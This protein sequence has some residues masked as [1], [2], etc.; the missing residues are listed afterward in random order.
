MA[1]NSVVFKPATQGSIT[2][3]YLTKVFQEAGVPNGII[4]SITGR[5]SEIGDYIITHPEINFINFTGST[6]AVKR[7]LV[8]N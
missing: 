4:N 1:G 6:A 2:G 5:G 8:V 3:I 7:I